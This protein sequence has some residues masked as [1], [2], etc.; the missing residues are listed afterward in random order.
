[1]SSE[2]AVINEM[3][4]LSV[5]EIRRQALPLGTTVVAGGEWLSRQVRWAVA[6]AADAPLPYLEGGEMILLMPG[7]GDVTPTIQGC[8]AANA[9]AVVVVSNLPHIALITAEN[10]QVPVLQLPANTRIRDVEQAVALLLLDRQSYAE[11]RSNQIYQQLIQLASD[12]AGL[13]QIVHELARTINKAVVVQDK[14]LR[15]EVY[16]VPPHLAE[17]WDE[18]SEF[19]ADRELLPD[20][21]R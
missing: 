14:R 6:A 21:L 15:V 16:A 18:I 13:D 7:K 19:L 1:M 3:Q 12:N 9:A 2:F 11:R 8:V 17:Q 5:E 10:A 20:S 4:L